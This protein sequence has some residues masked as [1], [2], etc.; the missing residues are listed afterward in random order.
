MCRGECE[1]LLTAARSSRSGKISTMD[2]LDCKRCTGEI[3]NHVTCDA[4]IFLKKNILIFYFSF[5]F[6]RNKPC[7]AAAPKRS[8][9]SLGQ[10]MDGFIIPISY[11]RRFLSGGKSSVKKIFFCI[12]DFVSYKYVNILPLGPASRC[13]E[14]GQFFLFLLDW[15]GFLALLCPFLPLGPF[16]PT[17]PA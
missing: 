15:A 2:I 11:Q 7:L 8:Q 16:H 3:K 12:F 13:L 10:L 14:R 4:S 9:T 5:F 1:T 17:Q 6:P